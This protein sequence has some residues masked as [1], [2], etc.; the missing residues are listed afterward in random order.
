MPDGHTRKTGAHHMG[1]AEPL[2]PWRASLEVLEALLARLE[3]ATDPERD[4]LARRLMAQVALAK[5]TT[6][7][8]LLDLEGRVLDVTPAPLA[9]AGVNRAEV[10]GRPLWE[11]A[12]WRTADVAARELRDA[13]A[14]AGQGRFSRYDVDVLIEQGGAAAGTLDFSLRPL[15]DGDAQVVLIVAEGRPITDR[16]RAEEKIAAQN[17][18][19]SVVTERLARIHGYR[20][21]L[22]GELSHDLRAPLQAVLAREER[23]RRM[24]E[25]T[26]VRREL[27][28]IRLAAL[29][30]LEQVDAMLEQVKRDHSETQLELADDDLARTVQL[31]A[32]QFE[33]LAA[34]RNVRFSVQ[35]PDELPARF[36]AERV[37]RV[38]SNL[39]AN[40]LRFTP[41]EGIVRCTLTAEGDAARI[42]VADSGAGVPPEERDR[43]FERFRTLTNGSRRQAGTGLGLA[44]VHEFV[45]L[46]GGTVRAD[47]AP[48]GGALFEVVLP[49][50]P[51]GDSEAPAAT[52]A[53]Q[54]AALRRSAFVRESLV[55]E[56]GEVEPEPVDAMPRVLIADADPA[57]A[58]RLAAAVEPGARAHTTDDA[59]EALRIALDLRPDLVVIGTGLDGPGAG[60]ELMRRLA[61]PGA[62]ACVRAGLTTDP[63]SRDALLAAGAQDVLD[64]D[65]ADDELRSRLG[66]L[67]DHAALQHRLRDSEDELRRR[68]RTAGEGGAMPATAR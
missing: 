57:R 56:L 28:G 34:E 60:V 31:V 51:A 1:S 68:A 65:A 39:L 14:A 54:L 32:G 20:E 38:I 15:R 16:K 61:A 58:R 55:A 43:L 42:E 45:A 37:S 40:A 44:I 49:R 59:A 48:E 4:V 3:L 52:L 24:S 6:F 67:L 8:A 13:V 50:Q 21:R 63:G 64:P 30:A 10:I 66:L 47:G 29:D 53:Q 5:S 62:P 12:W 46:H 25:D 33:P 7:I 36:D 17:A 23:I 19:L 41:A 35:T 9:A 27:Q 26:E 22:L 2:D 11:T 18:E